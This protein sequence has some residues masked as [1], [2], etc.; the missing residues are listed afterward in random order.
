MNMEQYLFFALFLLVGYAIGR[1][2]SFQSMIGIKKE[3][4]KLKKE[5]LVLKNHIVSTKKG[6]IIIKAKE[7]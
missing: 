3:N 4:D 5:V 6:R 7:E 1:V 2:S